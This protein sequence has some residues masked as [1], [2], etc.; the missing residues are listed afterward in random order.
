MKKDI[1]VDLETL[2]NVASS[3]I[4]SIGAVESNLITGELGSKFYRVIKLE[5]QKGTV[6]S[7]TVEWWMKQSNEARDVFS[8]VGKLEIKDALLA[9]SKWVH[10]LQASNEHIRLWGN[11]ASFDNSILRQAFRMYNCEFPIEF[12]NDRDMRTIVG[13]YPKQLQ[14]SWRRTNLR[15][16]TH[17]NALDDAIHQ[18]KYCSDILSELGVK[19]L[20]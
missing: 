6:N 20:Y 3:V 7:E 18:V 16:G 8:T 11:G 2:D 14:E 19:E 17:H 4:V 5:N 10:S 12:W 1:M 9:F 15:T 13:F